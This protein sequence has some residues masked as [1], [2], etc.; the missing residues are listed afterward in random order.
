MVLIIGDRTPGDT[1]YV[2]A[3]VLDEERNRAGRSRAMTVFTPMGLLGPWVIR[4]LFWATRL[5]GPSDIEKLSFIHF[6]RWGMI[7]KIPDLGQPKER[8]R[9]PLLMFESNY[10][11]SFD[12]YIDA[13]AHILAPGM[14]G[15]WG[16]SY[17][18]PRPKP[19]R[20]F[21]EYIHANELVAEHYHSAYPHATRTMVLHAL[22]VDEGIERL[23]ADAP[24]LGV[25]AFSDRYRELLVEGQWT[26]RRSEE[27]LKARLRR[28]VPGL[29]RPPRYGR[30]NHA[31]LACSV[32]S[33]VPIRAGHVDQVRAALAALSPSPFAD[34][35]GVH[36]GRFVVV[37]ELRRS[38]AGAPRRHT[39]LRSSYLLMSAMVTAPD[40]PAANA[41]PGSFLEQLVA[42]RTEQLHAVW[43]HCVSCPAADDP[44]GV[45]GWLD[46]SLLESVLVH[47][48]CPDA[49]VDQVLRALA[50][51]EALQQFAATH[52]AELD[53]AVVRAA[54]LAEVGAW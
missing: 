1:S 42:R 27:H 25:E 7:R 19:V 31:R 11:G 5:C 6:A 16:T 2:A 28:K 3:E 49:T 20:R 9:Q 18:F 32:T 41:L 17:G 43:R 8:L 51:Q 24:T 47:V 14:I 33:L 23:Q 13:F 34:V 37:D 46:R 29:R 50:R 30:H 12:G 45:V 44:A 54:F 15:M 40:G 36:F 22:A 53:R 39:R 10:N 4:P 21:I 38:W 35:P 48:G 52:Q 26:Q